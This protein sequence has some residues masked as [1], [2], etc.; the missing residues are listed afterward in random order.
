MKPHSTFYSMSGHGTFHGFG[1]C[2]AGPEFFQVYILR[3]LYFNKHCVS[4]RI[5]GTQST[6]TSLVKC[7]H[8]NISPDTVPYQNGDTHV[9]G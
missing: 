2:Q 9:Q 6:V 7:S 4:Q 1:L 3:N 8:A 5:T